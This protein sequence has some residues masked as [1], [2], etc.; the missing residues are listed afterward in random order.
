MNINPIIA[1][2]VADDSDISAQ[3][4]FIPLD[5]APGP[6]EQAWIR[7]VASIMDVNCGIEDEMELVRDLREG[8]EEIDYAR[9]LMRIEDEEQ[10]VAD[11]GQCV[12][13][14]R[15]AAPVAPSLPIITECDATDSSEPP[16]KRTRYSS[17]QLA[18]LQRE[19]DRG[20]Q[21]LSNKDIACEIDMKPDGVGRKV[22][23]A[24]VGSW[25]SAKARKLRSQQLL[26]G[27]AGQ[28]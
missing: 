2:L 17:H 11:E 22:T 5:D 4:A 21:R 26:S 14:P 3:A 25:M 24:D 28:P 8:F 18:L 1:D 15:V 13:V 9:E 23:A 7:D 6:D 10:V 27:G 12:S 19:F 20:S 16:K